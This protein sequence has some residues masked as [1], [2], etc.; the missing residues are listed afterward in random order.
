MPVVVLVVVLVVVSLDVVV[1]PPPPPPPEDIELE[2]VV[3]DVDVVVSE[4]DAVSAGEQPDAGT[5][6][7]RSAATPAAHKVEDSRMVPTLRLDPARLSRVTG[8]D[9]SVVLWVRAG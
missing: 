8:E 6:R 9:A 3:V 1:P 5:R 2:V 4:D 7:A